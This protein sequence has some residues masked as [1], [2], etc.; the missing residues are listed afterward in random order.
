MRKHLFAKTAQDVRRAEPGRT[1][2]DEPQGGRA[3]IDETRRHRPRRAV[4]ALQV[5]EGAAKP[6]SPME[7]P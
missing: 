5:R 4:Q 3:T 2:F 7:F 6:V 1:A